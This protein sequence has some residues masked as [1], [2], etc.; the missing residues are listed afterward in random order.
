M[1]VL[2]PMALLVVLGVSAVAGGVSARQLA[3]ARA[4][5]TPAS[6][7]AGKKLFMQRCSLCHLPPLGP[8][9]QTSYASSLAGF[10]TGPD[11]EAAA[12]LIVERGVPPRMPGFRYGLEPGEIDSIVAYMST[13]K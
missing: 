2:A 3:P 6:L 10:V 5:A 4:G 7:D 11:R 8:G 12:R 1:R 13:L 9:E